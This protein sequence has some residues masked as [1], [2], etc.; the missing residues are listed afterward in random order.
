MHEGI[1]VNLR[2][3]V[4]TIENQ[5]YAII[6][7]KIRTRVYSP[8]SHLNE[9]GI[10][11]ELGVSRSPVREALKRLSGSNVIEIIPNKGAFVKEFTQ[12]ETE[13]I[14]QAREMI[15]IFA[16]RNA[17][18]PLSDEQRQTFQHYRSDFCNALGDQDQF[19]LL[20][21]AF[22]GEIVGLLDNAYILKEYSELNW[23]INYIHDDSLRIRKHL[24]MVHSEHLRMIDLLLDGRSE[25]LV[26][27]LRQH[28][29]TCRECNV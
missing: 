4:S 16:V 24:E 11:E 25:E 18:Y 28:V 15:E 21:V 13:D 20:D 23:R 12:K 8:G 10:A 5:V 27:L 9:A 7:E 19:L 29:G 6:L 2:V 26:P 1:V 14:L 22:H 17:K 3:D